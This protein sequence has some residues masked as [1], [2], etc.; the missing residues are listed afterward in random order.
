MRDK[1]AE[2]LYE[3]L[4][5]VYCDTCAHND[6]DYDDCCGDFYPCEECHRKYMNWQMSLECAEKLSDKIL[7]LIEVERPGLKESY[8]EYLEA[9]NKKLEDYK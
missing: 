3:K 8:R 4:N 6:S 2:L 1:I 5:G 9:H 7:N